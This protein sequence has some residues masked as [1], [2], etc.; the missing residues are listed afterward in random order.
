M[1][2]RGNDVRGAILAAILFATFLFGCGPSDG[3]AAKPTADSV[4]VLPSRSAGV[5]EVL[6]GTGRKGAANRIAERLRV[7]GYD[8][9]KIGNA[10]ERN[11]SRTIVAERR[12][13][14]QV[15]AGV[16]KAIGVPSFFSFHNENLLVDAT[17]FVGRDF[18][19]ILPP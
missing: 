14:P 4:A 1:V 16:A 18:E 3:P 6:N 15:A 8:V 5:V 11:H 17:V 13:A 19:E 7:Q 9:V 2:F 12:A 10:P